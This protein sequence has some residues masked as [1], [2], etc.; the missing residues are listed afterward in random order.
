ML[1]RASYSILDKID[2]G[3]DITATSDFKKKMISEYDQK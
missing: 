3:V 1:N 2:V